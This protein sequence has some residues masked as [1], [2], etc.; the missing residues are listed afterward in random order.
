MAP[1]G[2]KSEG[3][4]HNASRRHL[5]P[6]RLRPPDPTAPRQSLG[7]RAQTARS[8]ILLDRKLP[9]PSNNRIRASRR[10]MDLRM[11]RRRHLAKGCALSARRSFCQTCREGSV[12][13]ERLARAVARRRPAVVAAVQAEAGS[14]ASMRSRSRAI[15]AAWRRFTSSK[16]AFSAARTSVAPAPVLRPTLGALAVGEVRSRKARPVQPVGTEVEPQD[17]GH[18]P[19]VVHHMRRQAAPAGKMGVIQRRRRVANTRPSPGR[20]ALS[21]TPEA[22]HGPLLQ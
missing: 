3:M 14:S 13:A 19:R 4:D 8:A 17:L 20:A 1:N 18:N 7:R 21:A 12:R 9:R 22:Q 2:P 6:L 10:G 5:R 11:F 16:A 15:S